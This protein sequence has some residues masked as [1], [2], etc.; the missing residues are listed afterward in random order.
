MTGARLSRRGFVYGA[1]SLTAAVL[2]APEAVA[3]KRRKRPS[4]RGGKFAEGIALGRS[5]AARGSRCGPAWRTPRAPAPWRS[6]WRAI[7]ASAR[8]WPAT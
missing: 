5:H 3:G 8:S 2:L 4:L 6:R 1:G 7:T